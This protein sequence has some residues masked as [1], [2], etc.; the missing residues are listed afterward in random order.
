MLQ[1]LARRITRE[2][3]FYNFGSFYHAKR[4]LTLKQ[5][6]ERFSSSGQL[7][8]IGLD[9]CSKVYA[10]YVNTVILDPLMYSSAVEEKGDKEYLSNLFEVKFF[11]VVK[12]LVY[13]HSKLKFVI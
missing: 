13:I 11:K 5:Y 7:C 10:L 6:N 8:Q 12:N 1:L 2:T 9:F 3:R 4:I